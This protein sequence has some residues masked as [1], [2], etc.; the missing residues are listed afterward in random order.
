[1]DIGLILITEQQAV[2][3]NPS[4][5]PEDYYL[6]RLQRKQPCLELN[7]NQKTIVMDSLERLTLAQKII[8]DKKLYQYVVYRPGKAEIEALAEKFSN[9]QYIVEKI[10][11]ELTWEFLDCYYYEV[12]QLTRLY[13]I[14]QREEISQIH[15]VVR[16]YQEVNPAFQWDSLRLLCLVDAETDIS[17][18][19]VEQ[20][21]TYL[22]NIGGLTYKDIILQVH[23]R[24]RQ[25]ILSIKA[26]KIY[27]HQKHHTILKDIER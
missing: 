15:S 9:T 11:V 22:Q 24:D 1:M 17:G 23:S 10:E 14:C 20:S 8:L 26:D 27:I 25:A 21:T 18:L 5:L 4:L 2:K 12:P 3:I 16:Q 7:E 13:L 19:A 6:I